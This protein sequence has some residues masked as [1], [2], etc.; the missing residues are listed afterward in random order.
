MPFC[1]PTHNVAGPIEVKLSP[2]TSAH[3]RS[4]QAIIY[5]IQQNI[6]TW[7]ADTS[8]PKN[9]MQVMINIRR[10]NAL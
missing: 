4:I 5:K 6:Y 8:Q 3:L 10:G 1:P 9:L 2:L 7:K